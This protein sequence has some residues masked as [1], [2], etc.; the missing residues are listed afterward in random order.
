MTLARSLHSAKRRDWTSRAVLTA[1][2][3]SCV[4]F[5]LVVSPIGTAFVAGAGVLP[6]GEPRWIVVGQ[7]SDCA[8]ALGRVM[9]RARKLRV[10]VPAAIY[11][12]AIDSGFKGSS[13]FGGVVYGELRSKVLR[14]NLWFSGIRGTPTLIE[15]PAG[16]WRGSATSLSAL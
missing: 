3:A 16:S 11:V 2:T 12:V 5:G 8:E 4:M 10:A 6:V 15:I 1:L 14:W 7:S 9:R 13:P